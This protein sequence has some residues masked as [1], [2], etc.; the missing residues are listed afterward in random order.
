MLES[1]FKTKLIDELEDLFPGCIV[2]HND[3]GY[4]QGIPDL[5]ILYRNKWAALEG[6]RNKDSSY[7]PNQEYYVELMNNMSFARFIYP[8]NKQEV[9][10]ELQRAFSFK[11]ST[12]ISKRQ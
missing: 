2:M 3:A 10:N 12:R 5:L 4:I 6:K 11:R 7:Q 9:L 1:R 8:E